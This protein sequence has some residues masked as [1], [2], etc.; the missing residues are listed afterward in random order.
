MN[1]VSRIYLGPVSLPLWLI[2]VVVAVSRLLL[3][4]PKLKTKGGSPM[5]NMLNTIL[6]PFTGFAEMVWD[7][8]AKVAAAF[9]DEDDNWRSC[10]HWISRCRRTSQA[11]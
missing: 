6:F 8:G 9:W 10:E 7:I 11:R 3:N 2:L 5:K 1:G 4:L